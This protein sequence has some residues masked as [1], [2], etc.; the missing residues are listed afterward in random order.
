MDDNI[1]DDKTV[2][3]KIADDKIADDKIADDKIA[4]DKASTRC[5]QK[6][7]SKTITDKTNSRWIYIIIVCLSEES[8]QGDSGAVSQRGSILRSRSVYHVTSQLLLFYYDL[9]CC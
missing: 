3:D 8:C 9:R 6:T 4:D 7:A 2:D 5:A 1:I